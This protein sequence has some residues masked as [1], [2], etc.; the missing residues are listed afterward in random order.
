VGEGNSPF[1]EFYFLEEE[2]LYE[3]E[4]GGEVLVVDE[5]DLP[6]EQS[7]YFKIKVKDNVIGTTHVYLIT[8][9]SGFLK[10]NFG[11]FP[12]V[13]GFFDEW[14]IKIPLSAGDE[15]VLN[16]DNNQEKFVESSGIA[17]KIKSR[18][19]EYAVQ[20][21]VDDEV[22]LSFKEISEAV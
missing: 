16:I 11:H 7:G 21:F 8:E 19:K 20:N 13:A 17:F 3:W 2:D 6:P 18:G 15:I 12:N 9:N 1:S 14:E 10:E 4:E 5:V 22:K